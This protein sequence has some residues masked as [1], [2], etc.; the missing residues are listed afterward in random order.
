MR[1]TFAALAAAGAGAAILFGTAA[2]ALAEPILIPSE[3][4][5]GGGGQVVQSEESPTGSVC[6]GGDFDKAFVL[7]M[8]GGDNGGDNG[9]AE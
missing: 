2:P 8:N 4:C 3:L 1:K 7:D 9:G 6:Q 5:V